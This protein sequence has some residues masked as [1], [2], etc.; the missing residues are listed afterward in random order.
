[1]AAIDISDNLERENENIND[2]MSREAADGRYGGHMRDKKN[3][4]SGR[5]ARRTGRDE[6]R[7]RKVSVRQALW[8]GRKFCGR[9]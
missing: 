8:S 1:M 2:K 4:V 9:R 5:K 7:T 6:P 3:T